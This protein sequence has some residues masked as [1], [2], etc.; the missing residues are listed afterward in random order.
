M[1]YDSIRL[2]ERLHREYD[3]ELVVPHK[4][5]RKKGGCVLRRYKRR[6][7]VERF[8]AGRTTLANWLFAKSVTP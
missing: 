6:W 3:V 2:G 4:A 8:F 7:K 1:V 5:N